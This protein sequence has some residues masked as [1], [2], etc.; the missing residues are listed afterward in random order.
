MVVFPTPTQCKTQVVA[1]VRASL[2]VM[3]SLELTVFLLK[4]HL[5]VWVD[6]DLR[7]LVLRRDLMFRECLIRTLVVPWDLLVV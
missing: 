7:V 4:H 1:S 3:V 5:L 2:V 6:L